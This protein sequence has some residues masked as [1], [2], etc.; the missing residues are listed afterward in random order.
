MEINSPS[1]R[2]YRARV[3]PIEDTVSVH[4]EGFAPTTPKH[5]RSVSQVSPSISDHH[6]QTDLFVRTEDLFSDHHSETGSPPYNPPF[7]PQDVQQVDSNNAALLEKIATLKRMFQAE[8]LARTQSEDELKLLRNQYRQLEENL[9]K[10]E[11]TCVN[12]YKEKEMLSAKLIDLQMERAA[13]L[14][15]EHG[16][17]HSASGGL[18]VRNKKKRNEVE[19]ARRKLRDF[20]DSVQ[21]NNSLL[22]AARSQARIL[23]EEIRSITNEIDQKNAVINELEKDKRNLR[24]S[25][26]RVHIELGECLSE[27][28]NQDL[29]IEELEEEISNLNNTIEELKLH[30]CDLNKQ[31]AVS[32]QTLKQKDR[33][34]GQLAERLL[35]L[36]VRTQKYRLEIRNFKVS[37]V[38][39]LGTVDVCINICKNPRT[40]VLMLEVS[41]GTFLK[42]VPLSSIC[43]FSLISDDSL[44]IDYS[45]NEC[46]IFNSSDAEDIVDILK[47]FSRYLAEQE[48]SSVS[49]VAGELIAFLNL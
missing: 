1:R 33:Q 46:E 36:T 5:S 32:S 45:E 23:E 8:R 11:S 26:R 6:S 40:S 47:E 25:Y 18:P 35:D 41:Y 24:D 42:I 16:D 14:E 37:K 38:T 30:I 21:T 31:L 12:L 4:S 9:S 20:E 19:F 34:N 28:T 43:A 15:A 3:A 10:K 44:R 2:R 22:E 29:F 17:Y 27:R 49:N 39:K 48:A 13:E 7:I